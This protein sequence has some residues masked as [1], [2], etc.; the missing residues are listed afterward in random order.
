MAGLGD[1]V[2]YAMLKKLSTIDMRMRLMF[3]NLM[4]LPFLLVGFLFYDVPRVS[5]NFYIV[6]IINAVVWLIALFLFMKALQMSDMSVSIPMLSFS[7]IFLLFVS[8]ILLGEFPSL[9]GLAGIIVVVAGSYILNISSVKYGYLE[10]FKLIFRNKGI[11]YM[12][13][14]AFL[15][16]ITASLAKMAINLSNP[17]YF[18]FV[19]YLLTSVFLAILFF[20]KISTYKKHLKKSFKYFLVSGVAGAFSEL[21]VSAAFSMAIVPYV[22]SLKRI[23]VIF[24]VIF[25]F[26]LFKEKNFKHAITGAIIMFIGA[27]MIILS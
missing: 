27:A 22:I 25:G 18:I 17:A 7:P 24:S 9:V 5:V 10:P 8:Y 26:L 16:S 6:I 15:F 1:A 20:R 2:S 11:F 19:H 13:V 4:P 12:L 21:A 3:Y 14:A 23:N